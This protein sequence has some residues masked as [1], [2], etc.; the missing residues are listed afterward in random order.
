MIYSQ[1][2][3]I[4]HP[5]T[6]SGAVHSFHSHSALIV[7]TSSDWKS[8]VINTNPVHISAHQTI[9][10]C[11]LVGMEC[12]TSW[13]WNANPFTRNNLPKLKLS[14][15]HQNSFSCTAYPLFGNASHIIF[16]IWICTLFE[17]DH[18]KQCFKSWW[19]F[20]L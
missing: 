9:S 20:A 2:I 7:V 14:V 1:I 11:E 6:K 16:Y 19:Y 4:Y 5:S 8:N 15:S 10:N 18:H 17:F 3:F 12:K 13:F